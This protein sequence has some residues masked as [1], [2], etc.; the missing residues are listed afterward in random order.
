MNQYYMPP[1]SFPILYTKAL[2]KYTNQ[3]DERDVKPAIQELKHENMGVSSMTGNHTF[4]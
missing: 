4:V 1:S 3:S 2:M